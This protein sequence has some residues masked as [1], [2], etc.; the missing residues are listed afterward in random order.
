MICQG[1]RTPHE[2]Q[3]RCTAPLSCTCQHRLVRIFTSEVPDLIG[4][5]PENQPGLAFGSALISDAAPFAVEVSSEEFDKL[6]K[7]ADRDQS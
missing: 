5:L 6:A 7:L 4:Q 2:G 1:C 3:E